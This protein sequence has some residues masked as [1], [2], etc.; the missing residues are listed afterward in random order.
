MASLERYNTGLYPET[1]VVFY[2]SRFNIY[3][4]W[5]HLYV[6]EAALKA[7]SKA[8]RSLSWAAPSVMPLD[9]WHLSPC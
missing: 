6:A 3:C 9:G 5:Q 7:V 1:H 4:I 8:S 2:K